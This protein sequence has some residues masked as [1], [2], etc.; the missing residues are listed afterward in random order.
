[1]KAFRKY[2][3]PK[4]KSFIKSAYASGLF[5][6]RRA[7]LDIHTKHKRPIRSRKD[8]KTTSNFTKHEE[9]KKHT[10]RAEN[11]TRKGRKGKGNKE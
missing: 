2:M 4:T 8:T 3:H 9:D 5:M 10:K 11:K 7:V 1:M 6:E